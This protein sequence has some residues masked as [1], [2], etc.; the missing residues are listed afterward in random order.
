M[1]ERKGLNFLELIQ[2]WQG[3]RVLISLGYNPDT[4]KN[5]TAFQ[6]TFESVHHNDKLWFDSIMEVTFLITYQCKNNQQ[7][8]L[9]NYLEKKEKWYFDLKEM[10]WLSGTKEHS[11]IIQTQLLKSFWMGKF[12]VISGNSSKNEITKAT[13]C[14]KVSMIQAVYIWRM[15]L[16]FAT[17]GEV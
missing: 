8:L 15:Y 9:K 7:L 17:L 6:S 3:N 13:I 12:I 14:W 4:L 1:R 11:M 2:Y 10:V 5:G 16:I